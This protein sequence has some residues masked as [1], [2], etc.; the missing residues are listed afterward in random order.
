M[1]KVKQGLLFKQK[2][3]IYLMS[4]TQYFTKVFL[5]L[6]MTA[7]L[8]PVQARAEAYDSSETILAELTNLHGASGFENEVRDYVEKR[9]KNAGLDTKV[10]G[11]GNL[12]GRFTQSTSNLKKKK[13]RKILV[14]AH[15]DEVGFITKNLN[16]DGTIQAIP[17]GGW[18]PHALW[19]HKWQ[20]QFPDRKILAISGIDPPHTLEDYRLNPTL[21]TKQFFLDTGKSAEELKQLGFRPGL[22]ITPDAK[23]FVLKK[24]S[25]Y[26]AKAFDDRAG[27]ALMIQLIDKLK[28]HPKLLE[29]NEIIFA[30]TVQEEVGMRGARA[31]AGSVQPD[32]ILNL[33]AGIARDYPS[34]F[35]NENIPKLGEGPVV[36]V[37]DASMLPNVALVDRI[38]KVAIKNNIPFQWGYE[39]T[40]GQDASSMQTAGNG[41]AAV[42][43]AIPI[44]Y[45]HSHYSIMDRKDYDNLLYL[46]EKIITTIS[47]PD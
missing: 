42:N 9:W 22:P 41:A 23:F 30:A 1:K 3:M 5:L 18:L 39:Q 38:S 8:V 44:R 4:I 6:W 46:L 12:I 33:E 37:F 15:L 32:F 19:A 35:S 7:I 45:A 36:F 34:Q 2:H 14:M 17:L 26:A 11:I 40:Y 47:Y 28:Q 10:D 16:T 29:K 27:I 21:T 43:L 24:K 13:R 25:R 20:I 31:I